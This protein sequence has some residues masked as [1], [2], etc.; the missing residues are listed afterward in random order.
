MGRS[1]IK[2]SSFSSPSSPTDFGRLPPMIRRLGVF[3]NQV[4][5]GLVSVTGVMMMTMRR[6]C[7]R[8]CTC[9]KGMR[10]ERGKNRSR[11]YWNNSRCSAHRCSP[12]PNAKQFPRREAFSVDLRRRPFDRGTEDDELVFDE[13]RWRRS[14]TSAGSVS[15]RGEPRPASKANCSFSSRH[16]SATTC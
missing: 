14:F 10:R 9:G 16:T 13:E 12:R 2:S 6:V 11:R 4:L 15:G 1:R 7:C 5:I 8:L 3:F